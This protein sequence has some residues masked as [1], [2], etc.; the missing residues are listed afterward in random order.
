MVILQAVHNNMYEYGDNLDINTALLQ[1]K[2]HCLIW[3]LFFITKTYSGPL[4]NNQ[5]ITDRSLVCAVYD[6]YAS[7]ILA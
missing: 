3:G 1:A 5:N 7:T 2:H 6:K 4:G